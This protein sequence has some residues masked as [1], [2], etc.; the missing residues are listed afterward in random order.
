[1][2]RQSPILEVRRVTKRFPGVLALDDISFGLR[3]G[4]V[5]AL[6]GENG[7][8]K[9]T[10][11]KVM[12]GV[13]G[14]D[15]GQ[16]L[17]QG[18]EVSFSEPRESQAA[19]ISTIYQEINLIPLLSVAQN[20]FL[21]REPRGRLGLIDR[22]RMN[23][24]AAEILERYGIRADVSAPLSSLGLGVQQMVAIA[25]AISVDARTVIMDEP[26]SSLEEREVETLFRV[27]RQL[28]EEEVGV[29]YVSHRLEE[30]YEI[31]DRVTVLRDG[32][33]A[34]TGEL[35]G[36]SRLQLIAYMLGREL[37]DVEEEGA[38]GFGVEHEAAEEP[39]LRAQDLTQRPR[40]HG[41]S[42]EV[43]PGEV[44][45]LAGLLG[46]GR[47]ETAKAIFGAEHV[48]S[49]SVKM[50]GEGVKMGSPAAAI[51]A[52]IAFL[53][54]D[55]KSEGIIPDLSVKE[56]IVAAALPRL[57]RAGLVSEKAQDEL[58]EEFM[59]SLDIKASSPDQPVRELSGGNQ[60]KVLLARWLCLNPKV[61]I[62][63]EPTRGI[64]VGAKAEIQ[65]L[66]DGL[67]VEGLG[68]I[69]ISS[70]LDEMTEGTDRVV[71]LRDG[72]VVGLLSEEEITEGN[73]MGMLARGEDL[74]D[75]PEENGRDAD[76]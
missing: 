7:A 36:L 15:E 23:R 2:D 33:V 62:L 31:C 30:L 14:P 16:I 35:A 8:G 19:G 20:V 75:E 41:I 4:E 12:T 51:K 73:L 25:R 34:H 53:P 60:Q 67:A 45:G 38:T 6:V 39:I 5:Q 10:L 13:Y 32:R 55:R 56:N 66:V 46:A 22:D 57:A 69:L 44:V 40:L 26:T 68:V 1:M 50:G 43:R 17:F 27:I 74:G 9:S 72:A 54:E 3:A 70:E 42:L 29:I 47:S 49:G 64:D 65:K 71:A 11:I 63:D 37:A 48:D 24:E 21:G 52:G 18:E 28:R 59:Q 61:L 76:G 58:V